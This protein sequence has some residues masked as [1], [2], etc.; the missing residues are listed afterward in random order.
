MPVTSV[1]SITDGRESGPMLDTVQKRVW[2]TDTALNMCNFSQV[3][4]YAEEATKT[5]TAF[6][7]VFGEILRPYVRCKPVIYV[8]VADDY[9]RMSLLFRACSE[10]LVFRLGTQSGCCKEGRLCE[11]ERFV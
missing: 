4:R 3:K 8:A 10:Y 6:F 9:E 5:P 11:Q 2:P 7:L 1:A